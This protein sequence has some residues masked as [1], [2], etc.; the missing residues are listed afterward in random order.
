[1]ISPKLCNLLYSG[2]GPRSR[3]GLAS[4]VSQMARQGQVLQVMCGA[5]D[6]AQL[7]ECLTSIYKALG[8]VPSGVKAGNGG[9]HL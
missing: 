6:V 3:K 8:S 2:K 4:E 1:M 7:V 5:R 9:T